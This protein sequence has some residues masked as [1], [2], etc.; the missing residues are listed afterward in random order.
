[1]IRSTAVAWPGLADAALLPHELCGGE[2]LREEPDE[3]AGVAA[4]VEKEQRRV[5]FADRVGL[6]G[7]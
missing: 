6:S 3:Q 7:L 1:M 2:I 5:E 4:A